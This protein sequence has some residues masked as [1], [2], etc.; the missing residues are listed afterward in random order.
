MSLRD[1]RD[2]KKIQFGGNELRDARLS[3]PKGTNRMLPFS[4]VRQIASAV[5]TLF[6]Y[7]R[8]VSDEL[9]GRLLG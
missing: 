1:D 8:T 9:R 4:F 7:P 3:Q 2:G 6:G 5:A